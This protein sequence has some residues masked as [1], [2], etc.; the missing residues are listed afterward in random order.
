M[1]KQHRILVRIPERKMSLGT[2][3]RGLEDNTRSKYEMQGVI[4]WTGFMR[5]RK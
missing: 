3:S 2:R 4:M 1:R 5:L